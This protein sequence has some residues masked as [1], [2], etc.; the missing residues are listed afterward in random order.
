MAL[1]YP[2][3]YSARITQNNH[4]LY[5][6][7]VSGRQIHIA[8]M[9]DPTLKM[10]PFDPPDNLGLEPQSGGIIKLTWDPPDSSVLGYNVYRSENI[11]EGFVRVNP[12]LVTDTTYVDTSPVDGWGNYMVRPL[13]LETSASGTYL[14]LGPGVIDSMEVSAG[15]GLRSDAAT[16]LSAPNP[17]HAGGKLMLSLGQPGRVVLKVYDATGR[18]VRTLDAGR[19]SSGSHQIE[20]DG[21]DSRGANVQPGVYFCRMLAGDLALNRKIVLMR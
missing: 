9:G 7:G 19:L 14:N 3:G 15:A 16:G 6:I 8:L 13:R 12:D 4:T 1:G 20:W 5:M 21:R 2:V 17:F 18:L 11:R 10:H